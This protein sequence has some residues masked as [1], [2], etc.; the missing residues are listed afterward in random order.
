MWRCPDRESFHFMAQPFVRSLGDVEF[1]LQQFGQ[2]LG[3]KERESKRSHWRLTNGRGVH[4][5]FMCPWP[6][7]VTRTYLTAGKMGCAHLYAHGDKDS[8][9]W[10]TNQPLPDKA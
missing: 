10:N 4:Q 8:G 1:P 5:S 2:Q 6:D 3:G 7:L 9:L